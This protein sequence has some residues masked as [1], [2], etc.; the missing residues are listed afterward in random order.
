MLTSKASGASSVEEK[1]LPVSASVEALLFALA[2]DANLWPEPKAPSPRGG[3]EQPGGDF[4][5]G[6]ATQEEQ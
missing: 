4:G 5:G 2:G 3:E 1:A 6:C